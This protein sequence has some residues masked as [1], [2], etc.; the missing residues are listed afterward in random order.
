MSEQKT[1]QLNIALVNGSLFTGEVVSVTVPGS[2]GDMTLL[3]DHT[4]LVS[5]L[6][7]GTLRIKKEDGTTEEFPVTSGTLEVSKN[8]VTILL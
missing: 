6:R 4:A 8:Q 1:L 5:V 3:A 2:E 7:P